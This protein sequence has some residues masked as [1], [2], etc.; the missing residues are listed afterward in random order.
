ME[1]EIDEVMEVVEGDGEMIETMVE[2]RVGDEGSSS[3]R[4]GTR[5]SQRGSKGPSGCGRNTRGRAHRVL[6]CCSSAA[7]WAPGPFP[8]EEGQVG[9]RSTVWPG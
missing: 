6:P 4:E 5:E 1:E 8:E 3:R 7:Y 9:Q 2:N